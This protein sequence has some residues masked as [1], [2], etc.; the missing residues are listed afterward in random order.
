M[1]C[2][3]VIVDEGK[4]HARCDV[5]EGTHVVVPEEEDNG[6]AESAREASF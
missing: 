2:I 6:R 5:R 3:H 1:K 4:A